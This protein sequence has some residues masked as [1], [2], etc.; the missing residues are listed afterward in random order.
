M[1]A[2]LYVTLLAKIGATHSLSFWGEFDFEMNIYTN[3]FSC[4]PA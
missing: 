4:S 3:V 2:L 1:L